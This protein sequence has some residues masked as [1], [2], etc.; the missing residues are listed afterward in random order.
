LEDG[1][2]E[3]FMHHFGEVQHRPGSHVGGRVTGGR[4]GN[5]RPS[6][7]FTPQTIRKSGG[8]KLR[9]FF[10]FEYAST[11]HPEGAPRNKSGKSL[12]PGGSLAA[13][14]PGPVQWLIFSRRNSIAT[15]GGNG[16]AT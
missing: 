4:S 12:N 1:S 13:T 2:A 16:P 5:G 7:G 9:S 15:G 8:L 3:S 14:C 6:L 11:C 10:I